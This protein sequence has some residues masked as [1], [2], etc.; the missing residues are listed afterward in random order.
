VESKEIHVMTQ[1]VHHMQEVH[2]IMLHSVTSTFLV[3]HHLKS[4]TPS[5]VRLSVNLNQDGGDNDSNAEVLGRLILIL[6]SDH[7]VAWELAANYKNKEDVSDDL[8]SA[9]QPLIIVS[10]VYSNCM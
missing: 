9:P 8:Y 7:P 4:Q 1:N 3:N 2:V 10:N 6:N 5:P